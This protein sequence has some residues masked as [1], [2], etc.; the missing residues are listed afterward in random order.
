M[1]LYLQALW[2][3]ALAGLGGLL[4]G[5]PLVG[6]VFGLF[7]TRPGR[8]DALQEALATGLAMAIWALLLGALPVF[9]FGVPLYALAWVR[10]QASQPLAVGM[11]LAAALLSLLLATDSLAVMVLAFGLPVAVITHALAD[12]MELP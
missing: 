6:C 2:R 5:S 3:T 12:R 8:V 9:L 1:T 4:L 11:A 10:G 7:M